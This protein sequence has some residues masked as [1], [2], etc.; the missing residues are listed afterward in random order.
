MSDSSASISRLGRCFQPLVNLIASNE[1]KGIA[2]RRSFN[3]LAIWLLPAPFAPV[4]INLCIYH[5]P[6]VL[7]VGS[8]SPMCL[9]SNGSKAP[10]DA[11]KRCSYAPHKKKRAPQRGAVV[12]RYLPTQRPAGCSGRVLLRK[13]GSLSPQ[14]RFWRPGSADR[15]GVARSLRSGRRTRWRSSCG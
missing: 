14:A 1:I 8:F 10:Q 13:Q 15:P 7:V 11:S 4:T 6:V 5:L 3:C 2:G 9:F 12:Y